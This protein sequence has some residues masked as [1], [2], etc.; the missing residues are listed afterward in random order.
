MKILVVNNNTRHIKPLSNALV[1]HE[2]EIVE[3][4]PGIKFNH[5]GKDLIIL[6]GGG[7]EGREIHD[8]HKNGDLWYKDE[9]QF[10]LDCPKPLLGICMGF[11][12]IAHA[13][14]SRIERLNNSKE[15]FK[16]FHT[17]TGQLVK[18]FKSHDY[19]VKKVSQKDFKVLAKSDSGIEMFKHNTRP[20]L[21]V[22]FHPELGGTL[23]VEQ[24]INCLKAAW[25]ALS[26]G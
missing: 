10:I 22:Q 20:I 24:L 9:L 3:Y 6:S 7:G 11:E 15:G 14:G 17:K 12:L 16:E 19:A 26:F 13:Y 18:Q 5:Q 8:R 2:L 21:G 1:G 4:H 25:H 23:S